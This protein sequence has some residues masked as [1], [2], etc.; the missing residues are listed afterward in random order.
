[1]LTR[2]LPILQTRRHHGYEAPSMCSASRRL[3]PTTGPCAKGRGSQ[4]D[5]TTSEGLGGIGGKRSRILLVLDLAII[6]HHFSFQQTS[7]RFLLVGGLCWLKGL[8][9]GWVAASGR[10]KTWQQSSAVSR[11]REQ[12]SLIPERPLRS[13]SHPTETFGG[14]ILGI[15]PKYI[16]MLR[17]VHISYTPIGC[18]IA[19]TLETSFCSVCR[20]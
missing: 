5:V 2:F 18:P 3:L 7:V 14:M 9:R 6:R 1:M 8:S 13:M 16:E 17:A 20:H 15:F 12:Q 19:A 4:P 11:K 10:Y